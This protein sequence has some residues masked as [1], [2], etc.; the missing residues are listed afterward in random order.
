MN[1]KTNKETIKY[2]EN[3]IINYIENNKYITNDKLK[4]DEIIIKTN[5]DSKIQTIEIDE[6]T[7][8]NMN[9]LT[10]YTSNNINISYIYDEILKDIKNNKIY[11]YKYYD[12]NT[13][14]VIANQKTLNKLLSNYSKVYLYTKKDTKAGFILTNIEEKINIT[15]GTCEVEYNALKQELFN[16]NNCNCTLKKY[17][18]T[19]GKKI[20]YYCQNIN[21]IKE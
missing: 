18:T 2:Q 9:Y 7:Y 5:Y 21:E 14:L 6:N 20:E 3:L 17:N 19:R 15:T 16:Y 1:Q 13:N 8:Q 10:I 11:L 12:N 4:D